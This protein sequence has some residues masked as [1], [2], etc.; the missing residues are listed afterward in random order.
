MAS[1]KLARLEVLEAALAQVRHAVVLGR[2][3]AA[4]RRGASSQLASMCPASVT[5]TSNTHASTPAI[6]PFSISLRGQALGT[7]TK[8]APEG[9]GTAA[10]P[11]SL[12]D[13]IVDNMQVSFGLQLRRD[14]EAAWCCALAALLAG[15]AIA[16]AALESPPPPSFPPGRHQQCARSLRR[17]GGIMRLW[18]ASGAR[19]SPQC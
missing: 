10:P 6:L 11:S 9:D 5:C 1:D 17:A 8:A 13:L 2:R 3:G 15:A 19:R 16:S 14:T 12:I 7:A 4:G 18:V